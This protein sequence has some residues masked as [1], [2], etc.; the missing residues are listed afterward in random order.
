[1]G[2][3]D[4]PARRNRTKTKG[5]PLFKKPENAVFKFR[6]YGVGKNFSAKKKFFLGSVLWQIRK[7]FLLFA[8]KTI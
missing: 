7:I 4:C 8:E 5:L 2:V 1:M 3:R 6:K